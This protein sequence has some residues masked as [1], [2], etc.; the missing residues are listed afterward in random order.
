MEHQNSPNSSTTLQDN[1]KEQMYVFAGPLNLNRK[2]RK[3]STIMGSD[4]VLGEKDF[5][6]LFTLALNEGKYMTF[7]Q[8]HKAS[9]GKSEATE[10]L[11]FATTALENLVQQINSTGDEFMWI[12]NTPE[13]GYRLKT[14]WGQNR[15]AQKAQKASEINVPKDIVSIN[16]KETIITEISKTNNSTKVLKKPRV[17]T[18]TTL[19]AGAGSIAAAIM[20]VL[21]LLYSTGVITPQE[22]GPL[23]I[24]VEDPR[25]PLAQSIEDTG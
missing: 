17:M 15:I 24:E 19:L 12:E 21:L 8:L 1:A 10:S 18:L 14:S 20:L 25:V 11:E 9:W 13:M 6:A 4:I 5:D 2:T 7:E 16:T 3:A 22:T 23:Y